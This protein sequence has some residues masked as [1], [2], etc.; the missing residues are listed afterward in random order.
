MNFLSNDLCE[1]IVFRG[2]KKTGA[3]KFDLSSSAVEI[4]TFGTWGIVRLKVEISLPT[5]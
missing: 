4:V 5:G 1:R 2:K 3:G